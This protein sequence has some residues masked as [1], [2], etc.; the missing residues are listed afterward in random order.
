M[1]SGVEGMSSERHSVI[2]ER[3]G[4]AHRACCTC[5][6]AGHSWNELRPAEADAWHHV[7]GDERVVDVRP[8]A[9]PDAAST[10]AFAQLHGR[11]EGGLPV[12]RLVDRARALARGSAPHSPATIEELA[13]AAA[14]DPDTLAEARD[15]AAELLRRHSQR[16]ARAADD[17]WLEL[18]TARRLLE[19]AVVRADA[20]YA[21]LR[22]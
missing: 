6:W 21:E 12:D 19:A 2:V 17:E 20:D 4:T 14:G 18:H 5:G 22:S 9:A 16:N 3:R 1:A 8:G 7:Y 11:A 13:K 15:R 10:A